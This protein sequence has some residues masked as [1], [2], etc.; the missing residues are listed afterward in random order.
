MSFRTLFLLGCVA[1]ALLPALAPAADADLILHNGKIVTVDK[2]SSTHQALAVVAA[3]GCIGRV[4]LMVRPS[5]STVTATGS[6]TLRLPR[7]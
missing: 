4:R 2:A 1:P 7:A 3:Y 5:R 6:P